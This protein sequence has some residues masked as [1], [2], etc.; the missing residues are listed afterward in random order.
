MEKTDMAADTVPVNLN[1]CSAIEVYNMEHTSQDRRHEKLQERPP[2]CRGLSLSVK[3]G[4]REGR[5][6]VV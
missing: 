5:Q 4:A 2:P 3:G 6:K 1:R